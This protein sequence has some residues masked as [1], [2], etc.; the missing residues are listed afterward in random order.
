MLV[1][2]LWII[3]N[4]FFKKLPPIKTACI[5]PDNQ[6]VYL[7]QK[8]ITVVASVAEN[9]DKE[10]QQRRR[11][12]STLLIILFIFRLIFSKNKQGYGL[13]IAELWEYCHKLHIPLPQ[14]NQWYL[15]HFV[16]QGKRWMNLF[17]RH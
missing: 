17:L 6:Q 1:N 9:F 15:L 4:L 5:T 7:W 14:A 10:W 3:K 11:V 16:T 8:I 2:Y 12:L 13:T